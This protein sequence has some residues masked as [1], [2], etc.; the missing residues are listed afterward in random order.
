MIPELSETTRTA[1]NN[2]RLWQGKYAGRPVLLAQT[3]MGRLCAQSAVA[4]LL[5]SYPI[6]M[7][8]SFGFAGGLDPA[9]PVGA[10]LLPD[11]LD[12]ETVSAN[13]EAVILPDHRVL[14][15]VRAA[16][17]ASGVPAASGL[18]VTAGRVVGTPEEKQALAAA[19]A[20]AVDM[21]SYWIAQAA[22]ACG[23]PF[24][25]VR[26]ISD[27]AG[28]RLP[29]FD[30]WSGPGGAARALRYLIARPESVLEMVRLS[31]HV[32]MAQRNLRAF[33]KA[34]VPAAMTGQD[35]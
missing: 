30:R 26:V 4:Y 1:V 5:A 10:L 19:G 24:L 14:E 20:Q 7:L 16:A 34:V 35:V 17:Q 22:A 6:R 9:L 15:Q 25:S 28:D 31:Q 32:R 27:A 2:L 29:P 21:E 18:L 13:P 11:R 8:V 23:V 33:L 12:A 3:G